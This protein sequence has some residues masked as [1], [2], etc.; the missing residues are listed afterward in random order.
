[1]KHAFHHIIA[2]S[3]GVNKSSKEAFIS[4]EQWFDYLTP[5]VDAWCQCDF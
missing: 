3:H 5:E 4:L 2:V 1:M